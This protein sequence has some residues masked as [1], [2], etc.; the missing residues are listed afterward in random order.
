[1]DHYVIATGVSQQQAADAIE[2]FFA[3]DGTTFTNPASSSPDTVKN[4]L[5]D[6]PNSK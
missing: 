5:F 6:G 1:L 2:R 4:H 3:L